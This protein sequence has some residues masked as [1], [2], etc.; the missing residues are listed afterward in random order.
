MIFVLNI[1]KNFYYVL[2]F[3]KIFR[4]KE[5]QTYLFD[6][7]GTLVDSHDSLALVF[8]GA[9]GAVGVEVPDDFIITLMRVPLPVGYEALNGPKDEEKIQLFASEIIRLLDD[10]EVLKATRAFDDVRDT[11][12]TLYQKG[13]TLG[14]VT[15]NNV[16]HVGE[17]LDF[18]EIDRHMFS[19]IIGNKEVKRHKPFPDPVLK[20]LEVLN[21]GPEGVCY[22]GDGQDDMTSAKD[23]NVTPIL[24]DRRNEY[25]DS[26]YQVIYSLEELI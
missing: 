3:I 19:V 12:Y 16:K 7:D 24:L 11:L 4:M 17:V 10:K 15:S 2:N 23:S 13:K 25:H 21:I 20:A 1:N 6:F 14:I 18:L 26:P 22:V 8:K 5:Y 9:Y